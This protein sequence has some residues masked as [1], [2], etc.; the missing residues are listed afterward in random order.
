MESS[1]V[2]NL[3][4][5]VV[6]IAISCETATTCDYSC[7]S[8]TYSYKDVDKDVASVTFT[9]RQINGVNYLT[10]NLVGYNIK[11]P[12]YQQ[13]FVSINSG[14]DSNKYICE[15][16][17]YGSM[18]AYFNGPQGQIISGSFEYQSHTLYC[19][20]T[21]SR[22]DSIWPKNS[23]GKGLDLESDS[24][25]GVMLSNIDHSFMAATDIKDLPIYHLKFLNCC[26]KVHGNDK[27]Q[28][29]VRQTNISNGFDI[30]ILT[31]SV[32]SAY[33]TSVELTGS[34]SS[35]LRFECYFASNWVDGH[36]EMDGQSTSINT[37]IYTK[38]VL[39]GKLC[40]WSIP[41]SFNSTIGYHDTRNRIYDLKVNVDGK[42][43]YTAKGIPLKGSDGTTDLLLII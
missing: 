42:D 26:Y 22:E 24:N 11:E 23:I 16:N 19:S 15:R 5:I 38:N 18:T 9:A 34:D 2:Q 27:V 36:L 37:Q 13:V 17:R 10:I 28:L 30:F 40:T 8:K 35:K 7:L 20:W 33:F 12:E 41:L 14:S 31:D 32:P 21:I 39:A 1:F 29:F 43:V 25:Y 6:I 4:L 3:V